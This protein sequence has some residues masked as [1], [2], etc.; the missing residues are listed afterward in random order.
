MVP[1]GPLSPVEARRV[2][3]HRVL[4]IHG[5]AEVCVVLSHGKAQFRPFAVGDLIQFHADGKERRFFVFSPAEKPE[6]Y[7]V[8]DQED[9]R[10]WEIVVDD[11]TI[12]RVTATPEVLTAR[13]KLLARY[14]RV[15]LVVTTE[16]QQKRGQWLDERSYHLSDCPAAHEHSDKRVVSAVRPVTWRQM[17]RE[18]KDRLWCECVSS[19]N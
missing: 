11:T 10:T 8:V 2:R 4:V 5:E 14:R 3:V 6:R 17:I 9:R 13:S 1:A 15:G 12:V 16:S 7:F 19:A 18:T